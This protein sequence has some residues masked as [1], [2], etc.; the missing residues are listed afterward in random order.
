MQKR[1][2]FSKPLTTA[3]V[4]LLSTGGTS[5][6]PEI[7]AHIDETT[8]IDGKYPERIVCMRQQVQMAPLQTE[9]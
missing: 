7:M 8:M 2:G 5:L 9:K 3:S 1:S 6:K 4:A